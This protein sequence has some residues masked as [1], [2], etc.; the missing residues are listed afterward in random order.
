MYRR[1]AFLVAAVADGLGTAIHAAGGSPLADSAVDCVE[2]E[3]AQVVPCDEAA[4]INWCVTAFYRP[5]Q[6]QRSRRKPTGL[7]CATAAPR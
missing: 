1:S 2:Q 3:L 5:R 4:W 6:A 7:T